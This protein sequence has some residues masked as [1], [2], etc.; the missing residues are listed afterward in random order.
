[1]QPRGKVILN[2][3]IHFN[4]F[5]YILA[6]SKY[7]Y[8]DPRFC[9]IFTKISN[10]LLQLVNITDSRFFV[11]LIM[12]VRIGVKMFAFVRVYLNGGITSS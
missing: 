2:T 6:A 11:L 4:E 12:A 3:I 5:S 7:F 10:V 1:M 8:A 9:L